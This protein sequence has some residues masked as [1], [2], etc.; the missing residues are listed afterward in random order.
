MRDAVDGDVDRTK[1]ETD[2]SLLALTFPGGAERGQGNVI[3][4]GN[5]NFTGLS[6]IIDDITMQ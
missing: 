1:E 6:P 2:Y 3:E 4:R 5:V